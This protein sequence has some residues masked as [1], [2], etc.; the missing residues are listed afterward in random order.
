[1]KRAMEIK[2][3]RDLIVMSRTSRIVAYCALY[4]QV[5]GKT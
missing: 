5:G 1:M 4:D 3:V 2:W